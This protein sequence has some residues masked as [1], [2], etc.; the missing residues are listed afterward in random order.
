MTTYLELRQKVGRAIQDPDNLTFGVQ[1]VKDVVASSWQE[2]SRVAPERYTE[3]ITP[4]DD[5]L[6]YQ[7]RADVFTAPNDDIELN[8]VEIWDGSVTPNLPSKWVVP[9]SVHPS[10]L[11]YS[12][13][14]WEVWAGL[15]YLPNRYVSGIDP[16]RHIIRVWGYSPW[17]MPVNDSDDI[18]IGASLEEALV[19][20][21]RIGF[22]ERLTSNRALFKQWQTRS[23]NT[24]VSMASLM[25][26][27]SEA[28]E[29]WRRLSRSLYV[30]REGV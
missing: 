24:D 25:S 21:T 19:I 10:G 26:D 22:L 30:Q 5:T 18:S 3:D 23:N 27:L 14:G 2:I 16:T 12:Q 6:S 15:L 7:L 9:K 29:K 28:E 20:H 4:L 1:T 17:E 8:R 11:S 13:A